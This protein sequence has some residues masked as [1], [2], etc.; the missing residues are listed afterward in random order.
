MMYQTTRAVSSAARSTRCGSLLRRA[1]APTSL[2][3]LELD[4]NIDTSGSRRT[5]AS[6]SEEYLALEDR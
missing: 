5:M 2:A 6:T 3:R 1:V 4:R